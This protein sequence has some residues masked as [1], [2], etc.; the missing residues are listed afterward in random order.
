MTA[1]DQ[2]R[3]WLDRLAFTELVSILSAAVDRADRDMIIDCY[4]LISGSC[5]QNAHNLSAVTDISGHLP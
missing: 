1:S 4:V 3:T 5:P 2:M